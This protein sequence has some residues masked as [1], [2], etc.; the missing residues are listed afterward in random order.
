MVTLRLFGKRI[1]EFREWES[2]FLN[3]VGLALLGIG[4]MMMLPLAAALY[5]GDDI[6]PFAIPMAFSIFFSLPLLLMFR[7][8]KNM[9]P[10]D[11]LLLMFAIWG[12]AMLVGAIPFIYCG[13]GPV[14]AVF[15]SVSGFTTTGSTIITGT[16]D[17]SFETLSK[18]I[19]LWR[20]LTQWIGG[21]A[22][23]LVF[24]SIFPILGVG[25]RT[26]F[27]NEMSGSG[28]KGFTA[29]MRDAAK[30]FTVIYAI[31]SFIFLVACILMGVDPFESVCLTFTTISTGGF[32]P[33]YGHIEYSVYV[34]MLIILFMF[35]G[36]TNFYLHYQRLY[37]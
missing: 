10:V 11:G 2:T 8:G 9:R 16:G 19:L 36:G 7:P 26:M 35:L 3:T 4:G 5:Y 1:R 15:E 12:I 20:S 22:I 32:L 29:R 17:L 23:I 14:D 25:G 18:S 6:T 30:E 33:Y 21:I 13:M 34:Q 31:L 37:R 27:R 24:M 28:S